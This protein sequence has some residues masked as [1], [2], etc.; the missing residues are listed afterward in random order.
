MSDEFG[1]GD[2]RHRANFA[3][4]SLARS[5]EV[6]HYS[7][8]C[9]IW[10]S[11]ESRDLTVFEHSKQELGPECLGLTLLAEVVVHDI[12]HEIRHANRPTSLP[13]REIAP[14]MQY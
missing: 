4:T 13:T 2:E 3:K 6:T 14:P 10:Y 11:V 12:P 1:S 7:R 5:F 9:R 8:I